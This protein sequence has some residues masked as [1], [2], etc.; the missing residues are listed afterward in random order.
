MCLYTNKRER[1]INALHRH[2]AEMSVVW[3]G[4]E[5]FLLNGVMPLGIV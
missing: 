1:A 2:W 4:Y 5:R 3:A